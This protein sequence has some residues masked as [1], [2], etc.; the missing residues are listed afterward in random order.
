MRPIE[1]KPNPRKEFVI[2][3]SCEKCGFMR[4]NRSQDDDNR[5]LLIRLTNPYNRNN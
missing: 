2:T 4:N 5:E 1:V 3:H